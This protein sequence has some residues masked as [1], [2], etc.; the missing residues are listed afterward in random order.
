MPGSGKTSF[1]HPFL[2]TNQI[3]PRPA[4]F[5]RKVQH[6]ELKQPNLSYIKSAAIDINLDLKGAPLR[7]AQEMEPG[8]R[9]KHPLPAPAPF[10]CIVRGST[11]LA[12]LEPGPS[13]RTWVGHFACRPTFQ[14]PTSCF[15]GNDTPVTQSLVALLFIHKMFRTLFICKVVVPTY[16][17]VSHHTGV[18]VYRLIHP[19]TASSHS[20]VPVNSNAPF[21]RVHCSHGAEFS[22]ICHYDCKPCTAT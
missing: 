18:T 4:P 1:L 2:D 5:R 14:I 12:S 20:T 7:R 13:Q 16:P 8:E 9:C 6:T 15:C 3:S 21:Q 10:T 22:H 19:G 17:A 11:A